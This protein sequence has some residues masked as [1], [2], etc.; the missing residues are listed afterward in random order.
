[1]L[2]E[3]PKEYARWQIEE[4]LA[5]IIDKPLGIVVAPSGYGKTTVAKLFLNRHPELR[6]IWLSLGHEEVDEVWVWNRLCDKCKDIDEQFHIQMHA[7]G[8]PESRQEMDYFVKML[9]Q[10]LSA[11]LILVLDDFHECNSRLMNRLLTH[12]IY[13]D[14]PNLHIL[15]IGRLYPEIPYEEL[16]LKGY[17]I[18]IDQQALALTMEESADI[19]RLNGVELS[20]DELQRMQ[21][22]TDGWIS[23][24]YLLLLDYK[25]QG[26]F[27]RFTSVAHLLKTAIF[28]KF[29]EEMQE[30]CA[31]MSPFDR[32]APEE[33]HYVSQCD[34][35]PMTLM[36][37]SEKFGFIQYDQSGKY[38][39]HTLLRSVA[40]G[41]LERRKYDKKLLYQ[42]DAE[43]NER[44]GNFITAIVGYWK[45]EMR[46][47]IFRILSG[48]A[49]YEI[50]DLAPAIIEEIFDQ[51][52]EEEKVKNPVAYLTYI[53]GCIIKDNEEKGKKLL[54]QAKEEFARA[55]LEKDVYDRL[56]GELMI[57]ESAASFNDIERVTDFMRKA[58]KILD[59]GTSNIFRRPLLTCGSPQM[60]ML[61][62]K[63]SGE[64]ER[65]VTLEKEYARYYMHLIGGVEGG[66]DELFDAEYA[67]SIGD[68]ECAYE[69]ALLVKKKARFTKQTCIIIS[70]YYIELWCLIYQGKQE[71]FE[72]EMNKFHEELKTAARPILMVDYELAYS[73]LYVLTGRIEQMTDWIKNYELENCSHIVRSI[74]SGCITYAMILYTTGQ[75]ELLDA[76]AG[77]L[78]VPFESA[79]HVYVDICGYLYKAV[80]AYHLEG[81][82]QA[83]AYLKKAVA[84]AEPDGLKIPFVERSEELTPIFEECLK[85]D[86]FYLS[87]KPYFK[88]YQHSVRLFKK[89]RNKIA[90]TD[91]ELELMELVR[92]GCR[93]GE[94]SQKMNIALVTVEK[95]LTNI[96]RKLNVTNRAAAIKKVNEII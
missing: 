15:I 77:Q 67:F 74:R 45:A 96:Y 43:W 31:K 37:V 81:T 87:L 95:N 92:A 38:E 8:L 32:F 76:M 55:D 82:E 39:M 94:I 62:Q 84:L 59:G 19:F 17:C 70:S 11:P 44:Q 34:I 89:E 22:Y 50:F 2:P 41:E 21:N 85:R 46:D 48:E 68:L 60:T 12:M 29:P 91:R 36:E 58:E 93:N 23:A 20:D 13:E 25:R 14:I 83:A 72:Q 26:R 64:L 86:K 90:L 80:A 54:E 79:R 61:Y 47:E 18:L 6:Y 73:G 78:L 7:L 24:V 4:R 28:D 3:K 16:Y 40:S 66:W 57:L 69:L 27:G 10:F 35:H 65:T 49:R 75:W 33:A 88:Q 71:L 51:T 30:A 1:M 5:E 52:S 53:H 63:K 42:R 56:R 9:R